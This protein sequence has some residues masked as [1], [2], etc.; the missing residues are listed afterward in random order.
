MGSLEWGRG[1]GWYQFLL[2]LETP[3]VVWSWDTWSL[4]EL[5]AAVTWLGTF[6]LDS[7]LVSSDSVFSACHRSLGLDTSIYASAGCL[8]QS[9]PLLE[10]SLVSAQSYLLDL[11]SVHYSLEHLVGF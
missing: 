2:I 8:P 4:E 7:F 1:M 10:C 3:Q 9:P 6:H 11:C 5:S